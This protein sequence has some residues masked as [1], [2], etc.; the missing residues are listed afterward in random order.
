MA[1]Q[2]EHLFSQLR[3]VREDARI[4]QRDLSQRTGLTQS[5]ISQIESGKLEPGLS[6]FIE[7]ARAL[8][9]EP[10]LI[11]KKL[12]PAV[13]GIIRTHTTPGDDAREGKA[14]QKKFDRALR[15]MKRLRSQHGGSADLD[16]IED[17][18]KVLQYARLD[19][20]EADA[21][22]TILNTLNVAHGND[23][24]PSTLHDAALKL[25]HLRNRS[26][27]SEPRAPRPAYSLDEHES[28]A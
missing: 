26:V 25:G 17:S 7:L 24:S 12:L 11:P 19:V 28:D 27:H 13:T 6:N 5:H 3:Q 20:P 8:D 1:Y 21:L 2:S 9:L 4:S 18:L 14:T 23:V 22:Q 16:R 10:V 15:L